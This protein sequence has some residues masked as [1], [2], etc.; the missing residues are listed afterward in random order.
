MYVTPLHS[1]KL[2]SDRLG[3][4]PSKPIR[5]GLCP[6]GGPISI[7]Y[8]VGLNSEI[9]RTYRSGGY[10]LALAFGVPLHVHRFATVGGLPTGI[11]VFH[12]L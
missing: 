7:P 8:G 1:L 5:V 12:L 4:N 9:G 3:K 6:G 2:N 11:F 10:S